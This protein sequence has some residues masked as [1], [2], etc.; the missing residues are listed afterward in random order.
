MACIVCASRPLASS[1]TPAGFPPSGL[2]VNAAYR[3]MSGRDITARSDIAARS[4]S[5]LD[6]HH[7]VRTD[8]RDVELIA[9]GGKSK[10]FVEPMRSRACIAPHH[11]AAARADFR[12]A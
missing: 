12:E 9:Q 8:R 2:S 6:L 4:P 7:V 11:R 5:Q 3:K 10:P 1:T